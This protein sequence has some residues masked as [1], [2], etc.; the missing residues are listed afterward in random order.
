MKAVHAEKL[1]KL[2]QDIKQQLTEEKSKIRYYLKMTYSRRTQFCMVL[3]KN[4]VV[5]FGT[6]A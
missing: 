6:S 4:C 2:Q 3:P 1:R 5:K